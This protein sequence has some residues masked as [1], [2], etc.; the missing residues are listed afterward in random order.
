MKSTGQQPTLDD[1]FKPETIV[2]AHRHERNYVQIENATAQD[3]RLSW[4]ARGLLLYLLSLPKDWEIRVSHLITQ[5]DLGRDA[6]RRTLRELQSFG[7]ASGVGRENQE[8]AGRGRFGATEIAVYESPSLNPFYTKVDS[9]SPENQS[10]VSPSPVSPSPDLPSPD[11]PSPE[12]QST[13]KRQNPQKTEETNHTHTNPRADGAPVVVVGV[14]KFSL[15]DCRRYAQHLHSTGQGIRN[16]GGFA[17][18]IYESGSEDEMIALFLAKLEPERVERGEL[19]APLDP[20][21]CPDCE[22]RIMRP[23]AGPGD[24]SK[25]VT[26]CRHDALTGQIPTTATVLS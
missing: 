2:R 10:T 20:S 17:R 5:G 7:Y 24:Y 26:K 8:R 12:N 25:G 3:K 13:Y 18:I 22:G 1:S 23:V 19:P 16:P 21:A 11:L 6:L 4:A 14:S 9:P 15:Q